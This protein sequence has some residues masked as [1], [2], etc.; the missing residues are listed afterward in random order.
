MLKGQ[1]R[2]V[3]PRMSGM[4]STEGTCDSATSAMA[5]NTSGGTA[6]SRA[7]R[8][9]CM[10]GRA[11]RRSNASPAAAKAAANT[12]L[13]QNIGSAMVASRSARRPNSASINTPAPA[14][15]ASV[16]TAKRSSMAVFFT[17]R[18]SVASRWINSSVLMP[19]P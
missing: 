16:A 2:Q 18:S 15:P 12:S 19:F 9:T 1:V 17:G 6:S 4:R 7:V 8:P 5:H 11:M 13:P 10:P 14:M 3:L